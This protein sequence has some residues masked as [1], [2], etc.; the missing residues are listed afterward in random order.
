MD[1]DLVYILI[2][3]NSLEEILKPNMN[4][5]FRQVKHLLFPRDNTGE[6]KIFDKRTLFFKAEWQGDG[7]FALL[8]KMNTVSVESR[9]I[10]LVEKG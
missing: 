1:T 10:N 4:N 2:A 7:I 9:E 6:K 8:S 5:T 3:G